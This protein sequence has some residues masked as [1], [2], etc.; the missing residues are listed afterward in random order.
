MSSLWQERYASLTA[1][2]RQEALRVI[3]ARQPVFSDPSDALRALN[4]A[5][6]ELV[7]KVKEVD[8]VSRVK[9]F[10]LGGLNRVAEDYEALCKKVK[11][12]GKRC[13]GGV[14]ERISNSSSSG[15]EKRVAESDLAL[16]LDKNIVKIHNNI[17]MP[18]TTCLLQLQLFNVEKRFGLLEESYEALGRADAKRRGEN[19]PG[20]PSPSFRQRM[21]NPFDC[22]E[23]APRSRKK[24]KKRLGA[25]EAL[26]K[27]QRNCELALQEKQRIEKAAKE[28]ERPFEEPANSPYPDLLCA[29]AAV[30][31]YLPENFRQD[32]IDARFISE[33]IFVLHEKAHSQLLVLRSAF[34]TWY[35]ASHEVWYVC[36][37]AVRP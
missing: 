22:M 5:H 9:T 37:E 26:A 36:S 2:E 18:L 34:V 28:A 1:L 30:P 10:D 17:T 27:L 6:K 12:E 3:R 14:A 35:S 25:L 23:T 11:D 21:N 29:F 19:S 24:G 4:A 8:R 31:D 13:I 33:E 32:F 16:E 15:G 7:E 20:D